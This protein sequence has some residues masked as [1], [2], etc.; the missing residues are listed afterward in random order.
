MQPKKSEIAKISSVAALYC[1]L[2]RDDGKECESNSIAN[3]K[4]MLSD[5]ALRNG[6]THTKFYVDDGYTG[7]NFER[8]GFQDMLSDIKS[9]IVKTVLVKDSSRLG[10]NYLECGKY[11]EI[12]FP[13]YDVR[14]ISVTEGIDTADGEDELG[15]VRGVVNDFYA[16]DISRKVKASSTMRGASGVPL[17][18][19]PYGYGKDPDDKRHWIVDPEAAE[20]VRRIFALAMEGKPNLTIARI[21]EAEKILTPTAFWQRKGIQRNG[22]KPQPDPY[23]WSGATIR[24][25]LLSREYCGDVV[26][27]KTHVKSYRVKKQI[28]NPEEMWA[29]FPDKHEPIID[30]ETFETVQKYV[31]RNK[32]R[33]PKEG[34]GEKSMF[35]GLV[36]CAD[37]GSKLWFNV[38][39]PNNQIRYFNCSNYRGNRGTCD[40][41][42]YIRED[43]LEA[44]VKLE[45]KRLAAYLKADEER[46]A[47]IIEQESN[48]EL[49]ERKKQCEKALNRSQA[50]QKEITLLCQKLYEDNMTGKVSDDLF[51]R[52]T[53]KYEEEA[54]ELLH[55]AAEDREE[56][57]RIDHCKHGKEEF[58]LAVKRFMEMESLTPQIVRELIEKIVVHQYE[59]TGKNRTQ[60][61]EIYYRFIGSINVPAGDEPN[62]R[63]NIRQGVA[64][65]YRTDKA[66]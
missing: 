66:V 12:V 17:S 6:F 19:P 25:I 60:Q 47:A 8:P 26:N 1:R 55:K 23:R 9:G 56:I 46:F 24:K 51:A 35:C 38:N 3:Q 22:A 34:N 57:L 33:P 50:R 13:E 64:I 2:S 11:Q 18:Q 49:L 52:L 40:S 7:T 42:H 63:L 10:R 29:I 16:R 65:E 43:A 48:K 36:Y 62:V 41:T 4:K 30:R 31:L 59:G 61:I 21:L 44:I 28:R 20:V 58:V 32:R 53:A 54:S 39:H 37:C 27:F 5:Y 45:L 15:P 14:F